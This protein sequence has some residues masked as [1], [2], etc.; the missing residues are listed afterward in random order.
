MSAPAPYNPAFNFTDFQTANPTTPLP[1][2]ALDA[3]LF[4]VKITTDQIIAAL[5]IIQRSDGALFNGIV[6]ADSLSTAVLNLMGGFNPRGNWATTTAYNAKDIVD[7]TGGTYVAVISHTSGVFATDLAAGKWNLI[8]GSAGSVTLASLTDVLLNSPVANNLLSFNGTDWVNG[9]LALANIAS[10]L[11]TFAKLNSAVFSTDGTFATTNDT[12]F[13]TTKSVK[14]YL[15]TQAFKATGANVVAAATTSLTGAFDFV[16]VTGNTTISAITLAANEEKWVRFTGTPQLT[17]DA[18]KLVLPSTANIAV[19]ANDRA[20]FRGIDGTNVICLDYI[21]ASGLPLVA[22]PVTTA[23]TLI[24]QQTVSG[25]ASV[26]VTAGIDTTYSH[27]IWELSNLVS[28]AGGVDALVTLQQSGSF[29]GGS[30]Y[31]SSGVKATGSGVAIAVIGDNGTSSF[32]VTGGVGGIGTA[33]TN[34]PST[35]VFELWQPALVAIQNVKFWSLQT[36]GSGGV[37]STDSKGYLNTNAATTGLKMAL[38]SGNIAFCTA[39]LYGVS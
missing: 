24:S 23:M 31:L 27:Y 26:A 11:I 30:S 21:R 25:V 13:P 16:M 20:L 18:T 14:T 32:D 3:E 36:A 22:P 15:Q 12:T 10:G 4:D 6:T 35:I 1:A 5:A 2:N 29:V 8:A 9:P 38:S 17:Y 33:M 34:G 37:A 39:K 28:V 19:A 7:E